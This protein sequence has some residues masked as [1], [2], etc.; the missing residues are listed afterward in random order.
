MQR[1]RFIPQPVPEATQHGSQFGGDDTATDGPA[2]GT[3]RHFPGCWMTMPLQPP[4]PETSRRS[5]SRWPLQDLRNSIQQNER[6]L[7][8]L[9]EVRAAMA[10][11][12]GSGPHDMSQARHALVEEVEFLK[13]TFQRALDVAHTE[14]DGTND[15]LQEAQKSLRTLEQ[16]QHDLRQQRDQVQARLSNQRA[17]R[18][19]LASQLTAQTEKVTELERRVQEA[20][21]AME[22]MTADVIDARGYITHSARLVAGKEGVVKLALQNKSL[23]VAEMS[24]LRR[25]LEARQ[26]RDR[27][28]TTAEEL[29]EQLRVAQAR[30]AQLEAQPLRLSASNLAWDILL[31]E[32]QDLR[33]AAKTQKARAKDSRVRNKNPRGYTETFQADALQ[34]LGALEL[35][36]LLREKQA[37]DDLG[38]KLQAFQESERTSATALLH[39]NEHFQDAVPSFW[40]WVAQHLLVSEAAGVAP[41][42]EAWTL[43]NPDHFKSCNESVGVISTK[44]TRGLTEHLL[45]RVWVPTFSAWVTNAQEP[46]Q[47]PWPVLVSSAA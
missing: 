38:K 43:S 22:V 24:D 9:Q 46:S 1:G 10:S 4:P 18:R 13:A 7:S 23:V 16:G 40:D 25:S 41:L 35:E 47:H 15:L 30:I 17:E 31:T 3:R 36:K 39:A 5:L 37:S 27:A 21:Q 8:V 29:Q 12:L 42:I 34:T 33:E 44:A 2:V 11:T 28:L 45:R 6:S 14:R 26:D 19:D 32:N 20:D